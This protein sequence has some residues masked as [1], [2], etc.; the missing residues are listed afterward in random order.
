MKLPPYPIDGASLQI[1]PFDACPQIVSRLD[2]VADLPCV[3]IEYAIANELPLPHM[4]TAIPGVTRLKRL[5]S[6]TDYRS[7]RSGDN[8]FRDGERARVRQWR[9]DKPDKVRDQRRKARAENYNKRFVAVDSEGQ[10][11]PGADILYDGVRYA[12][13]ATYL[14]GAAADDGRPPHWLSSAETR[15]TD[16]K[17]LGAAEI[18]D[19]LLDLPRDFGRAVFLGFSI[20]YDVTQILSHLPCRTAWE[21]VKRETYPDA[22][23]KTRP[24][25]HAPVFWK[26][27]AIA[28][29][30]G[31]S[32]DIWRLADPDRPWLPPAKPGGKKRLNKSAHIR[33]FD[34]FG[35]FQSSFSAVTDS[36]VDSGRAT[37][38]EADYMRVM[39]GRRDEFATVPIEEI[40]PYTT[41][42]LRLLARMM[43]DLRNGFNETG[44]HLRG[45]HG[46]GAAAS[47]LI[48]N[49]KLRTQYGKD[50]AASDISP[51]QD[52]AHHAYFGGRIELL[53]QGYMEGGSLHV[54]DI[55]SA[56]PAAMVEFPS[57]ASGEWI[58]TRHNEIARGTLPELRAVVEAASCV[59][60]FKI[61][62][63]F[64]AYAKYDPDARK[65]VFIPFYPLPYRDR[66]GGILFPASGYGWYMRDDVLAAIA[67]LERFVPDFPLP[68][69]N[70]NKHAAFVVEEA[71][72]FEP[73]RS[74]GANERP[75]AFIHDRFHERRRIKDEIDRT[76]NY[77]IREKAIK[78]SIN[79]V[80]GKLAQ[81]VG[82][83]GSVPPV[84]NPY[85]AAASTAYCRRRR[86][87]A[88]LIDPH[89]I[90]FFATDGIVATSE[91]HGLLRMRKK[92]DIVDLGDWEYCEADGGLFVLPGVYTYGKIDY[93]ETGARTINPVTK[94]RG[95]DAKKYAATVKANQWLIENVLA[96]WRKPF[97]PEKPEQFPRIVAGYQKYIT[98][99][100][101]LASPGR[102]RLAGRWTPRPNEPDAGK[103]EILVHSVGNKRELVPDENCWPDYVSIPGREARRCHELIRTLPAMNNDVTLSRPRMPEWMDED[104]GEEVEDQEE[105]EELRAGFE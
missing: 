9:A 1:V 16:K 56:Y 23:G 68:R 65:A 49:Q 103:R 7:R 12:E 73:Q 24:I 67:W 55:A 79:A 76:G 32:I 58:N 28:Y 98:V 97:D 100:N 10:N 41:L 4:P 94:I 43:T 89:S 6:K 34:V 70:A 38:D 45:W 87:E 13:H 33:I 80:Y 69:K 86:V 72:I 50:I 59:S 35:F 82:T 96:A 37:K 63:Q 85:Y 83:Q 52:A 5:R 39:K 75:F 47:A 27:Y 74:D 71:W 95:G 51:Q 31:K 78:L 42:E 18:L 57:L 20:G 15:G 53:K 104:I 99:G 8:V 22:D 25:G 102:W 19:W 48:E 93:D 17:P 36:M 30:K 62:Y 44:L 14:W 60:M 40:K 29:A 26:G 101:A 3:E 66:R 81:K 88:A 105:Q 11:Y 90:V 64:P 77:D 92:G 2:V 84:A 54:Y 21:I 61:R 91:L 46:A